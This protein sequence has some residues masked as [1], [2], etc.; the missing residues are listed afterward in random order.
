MS[1]LPCIAGNTISLAL[2]TKPDVG[3][4]SYLPYTPASG[5]GWGPCEWLALL[6]HPKNREGK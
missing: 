4:Q 6:Y 2:S 1:E 5:P 3:P